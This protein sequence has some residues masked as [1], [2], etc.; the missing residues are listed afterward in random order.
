M[1]DSSQSER[2]TVAVCQAHGW[3]WYTTGY[4]VERCPDPG[5]GARVDSYVYARSY[6]RGSDRRCRR[7]GGENTRWPD[8]YCVTCH[9]EQKRRDAAYGDACVKM[10]ADRRLL[11]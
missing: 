2:Q 1:A 7:C 11:R 6:E 8:G 5:C 3:Y 4:G 9:E 10:A